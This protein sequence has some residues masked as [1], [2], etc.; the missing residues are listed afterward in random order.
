MS[1]F[2]GTCRIYSRLS[3]HRLLFPVCQ[4]NHV[5]PFFLFP[6]P[7]AGTAAP[8]S[9][10]WAHPSPQGRLEGHVIKLNLS[11]NL[12][13]SFEILCVQQ[14]RGGD[15]RG[16]RVRGGMQSPCGSGR[17]KGN[18]FIC[19]GSCGTFCLYKILGDGDPHVQPSVSSL[20]GVLWTTG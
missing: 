19:C 5:Q 6:C 16:G 4:Q 13:A 20:A 9:R 3:E 12:T 14:G 11:A 2:L 18:G 10:G 1:H 17:A 8:G 15:G 7:H